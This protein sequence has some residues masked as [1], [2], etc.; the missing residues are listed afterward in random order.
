MPGTP[1]RDGR[2]G[3]DG[4]MGVKVEF[5]GERDRAL[6][7]NGPNLFQKFVKNSYLKEIG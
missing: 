4:Q 2:P 7:F 3:R 6:C 5:C 1:G